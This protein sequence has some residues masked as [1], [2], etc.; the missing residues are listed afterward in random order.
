[1]TIFESAYIRCA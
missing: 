1:M